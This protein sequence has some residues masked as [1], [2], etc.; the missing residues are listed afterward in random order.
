MKINISKTKVRGDIRWV[1][2]MHHD[3]K[4]K[5]KFFLS[6]AEAQ[7]FDA[8]NWWSA[9]QKKEPVGSQ[10]LL[11]VARDEYLKWYSEEH[12]NLEKPIQT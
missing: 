7:V 6:L 5:R 11:G 3:G 9:V 4:R 10:T 12:E 2:K 8:V 1:L